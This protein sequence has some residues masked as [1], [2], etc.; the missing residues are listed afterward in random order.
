MCSQVAAADAVFHEVTRLDA[1]AL[2]NPLVAGFDAALG[3]H[4]NHVGIGK[5]LG[6]QMAAGARDAGVALGLGRL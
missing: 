5:T 6:R 4:R 2:D 1:S 3:Q